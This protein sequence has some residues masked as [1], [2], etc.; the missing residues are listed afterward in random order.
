MY[1]VEYNR[2][3]DKN[4]EKLSKPICKRIIKKIYWL[5][6]CIEDIR[7]DMLGGKYKD[8]YKLRIGDW[9]VIYGINSSEKSIIIYF[10][11]HRKEIYKII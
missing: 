9:R 8:L 4:L 2:E 1:K 5:S 10:A 7:P 3:A 6:K 11:G